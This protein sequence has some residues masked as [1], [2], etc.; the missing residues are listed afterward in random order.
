MTELKCVVDRHGTERWY[1]S[2]GLLHREYG[3]AVQYSNGDKEWFLNG[4]R[5]SESG[6]SKYLNT[7]NS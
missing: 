3:A 1:D 7:K 2:R 6:Y 4:I 5:F